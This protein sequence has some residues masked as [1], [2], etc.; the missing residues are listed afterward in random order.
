MINKIVRSRVRG[1]FTVE[2]AVI[3]PLFTFIT[4]SL[5]AL[6]FYVRNTVMIRSE[7][8]KCAIEMERIT[9]QSPSS[10]TLSKAS[11]TLRQEV[12]FRGM[13][14]KNI[15]TRVYKNEDGGITVS[16]YADS[17][18]LLPLFGRLGTISVTE[19][20]DAHNP[21]ANMRRWNAIG[22]LTGKN[23]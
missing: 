13:F 15:N 7:C 18:A 23:R 11:D 10:D 17:S 2:G 3:I 4:V 9:T 20:A 1:S 5:I 12:S 19:K 16:A 21:A 6:G 14:L 8:W 22:M